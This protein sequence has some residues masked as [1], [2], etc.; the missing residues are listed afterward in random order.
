MFETYCLVASALLSCTNAV[1]WACD[2]FSRHQY[3]VKIGFHILS[4]KR[5]SHQQMDNPKLYDKKS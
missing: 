4:K 3:K 1:L 2:T 5:G